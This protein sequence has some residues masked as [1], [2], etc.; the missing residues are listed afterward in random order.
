MAGARPRPTVLEEKQSAEAGRLAGGEQQMLALAR[1][2]TARP[3]LLLLDDPFLGLG[4]AVTE[5][6]ALRASVKADP[7]QLEQVIVNLAVNARDAMPDGGRLTVE[8][9][10]VELEEPYASRHAGVEPGRYVMLAVTDTGVGMDAET[11]ARIFEPFFTTKESRA[12]A[13]GSA[14]RP[15]TAS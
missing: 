10:N 4:R 12:R 13:P 11:R 5:R 1:G 2:L 7:G 8:T 14:C 6:A 15:C 3:R 9:S